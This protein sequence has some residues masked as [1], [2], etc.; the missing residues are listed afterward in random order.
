MPWW[1]WIISHV[2]VICST[3]MLVNLVH[4][5]DI[6]EADN[7][8]KKIFYTLLVI[9]API[10]IVIALI[11]F[12]IDETPF[13]DWLVMKIQNF[14]DG[15]LGKWIIK[16]IERFME[17]KKRK[18]DFKDIEENEDEWNIERTGIKSR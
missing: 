9:F 15:R 6:K 4:D 14:L 3:F 18:E 5:D 12:V 17:R 7:W 2:W 1:F 16:K 10:V 8:K 11:A 13:Q